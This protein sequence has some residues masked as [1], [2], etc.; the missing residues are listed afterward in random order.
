[1]N[2]SN[3]T[4]DKTERLNNTNAL[5][6]QWESIDWEQVQKDVNRLQTRIA[7]A[8]AKGNR[9]KVKRLQYLLTHSFCAKCYAVKKVTS[10]K[11]KNTSGV[12]HKLWSTPASKM[13]AVFLLSD[14][15]Y[16]TMP[17]RRVYIA[18]KG[19]N[20]K[21]PL[22]IPTM[23]DRAMQT[24]YALALEPVA[25]TTGDHI[26]FGF[27]KGRSAKDACE[28]IFCVLARK[29][30][31]KWILEGDIKG[32]FDNINHDW[33]QAH[34]PMDKRIMKRFLKSGFVYE[35]KL[36]PTD[37][38]SPQGGAISSLYANMTLDGL[39]K[40]I[41]DK[42]HRNSKGKIENHYRAKTKVNLVRYADDFII[43]ANTREL[44][45]ELKETVSQFL[46]SRGLT[47]SEEKTM[48]TQIDD[49]FDFLGWTFRK[50]REKL[51]V[52]PSKSAIKSIIGKCSTIILKE[53]KAMSQ[54]ELIRRLNQV[55]RGW[56]NYHR[57][58]VASETFSHINNTLYL[59]LQQWAKHR[60]PNKNKW[61]RLNKYW[62]E[63]ND[64]RWLFMSEENSL[65]NL[66][67]INIVRQP[68]L[69]ISKNPF[70]DEGYFI[71]KKMKLKSLVAARNGEEM[72]EPYERETLTYGS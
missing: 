18:K 6:A 33:L 67:S 26:S 58:V 11:G 15:S 36:F 46:T 54:S 62:H 21:R 50:F 16:R 65:I 41:Q 8:T 23:Y 14:K 63:K 55:I 49:G 48:I 70:L 56:S 53:G 69:Q 25:E 40:L 29:C 20:K 44:A 72:L 17:L 22:G 42:Y 66:R 47:L 59:L 51:M 57:H 35:G 10:N 30:S 28:Q 3:S 19:K 32:C 38:G 52:K 64:K 34:I 1:M 5:A 61:W 68:K 39:E 43:T 24:L 45:V 27:R 37:T 60:H 9:N 12:D 7:K 2:F 71:K 31:P 13:K 4:T